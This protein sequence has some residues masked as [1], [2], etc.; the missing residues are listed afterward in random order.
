MRSGIR[1]SLVV[2]CLAA[3][4]AYAQNV[5]QDSPDQCERLAAKVAQQ[6]GARV[7]SHSPPGNDIALKF[8]NVSELRIICPANDPK[9]PRIF[10][11]S[12]SAYPPAS[13]YK[14]LAEAGQALTG[15]SLRRL[16][17]GAHNCHRASAGSAD[18]RS[19]KGVRGLSFECS[20]SIKDRISTFTF[21]RKSEHRP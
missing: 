11:K 3:Q 8:K 6:I 13:F 4:P 9:R 7:E 20:T 17:K 2:C 18:G 21:H 12:A 16:N 5:P 19:R 15:V 1:L 14:L 10:I